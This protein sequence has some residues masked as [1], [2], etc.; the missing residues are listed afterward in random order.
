[1]IYNLEAAF[2]F[3]VAAFAALLTV[4]YISENNS[5]AAVQPCMCAMILVLC[6]WKMGLLGSLWS[7]LFLVSDPAY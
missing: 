5:I 3:A 2:K 1:L 4:N 6:C 7:L